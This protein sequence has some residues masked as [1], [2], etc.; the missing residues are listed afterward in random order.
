MVPIAFNGNNTG[1][2]KQVN[3]GY[4][5]VAERLVIFK[6]KT[7]GSMPVL[8]EVKNNPSKL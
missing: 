5:S 4:T 2:Q 7:F 6:P 8:S 1:L 3:E